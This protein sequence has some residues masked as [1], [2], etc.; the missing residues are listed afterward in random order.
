MECLTTFLVKLIP[1]L[2]VGWTPARIL[3]VSYLRSGAWISF[4]Q[5][6][7]IS[8]PTG[9]SIKAFCKKSGLACNSID[10]NNDADGPVATL[11]YI[12]VADRPKARLLLYFHGGAYCYPIDTKGQLPFALECA[13]EAGASELVCLEYTL[14]PELKYPGQLVQA[15]DAL[16]YI[17]QTHQPSQIILGGDSAG[18]H[19]VL[20]L[21]A[22]IQKPHPAAKSLIGRFR[23]GS[24]L[25][26]AYVISPWVSMKYDSESFKQNASRDYISAK[27]MAACTEMWNPSHAQVWGELLAGDVDFWRNLPVDKLLL[28]AGGWECFLDD[29]LVM[30]SRLEAKE[31]GAGA[32]VELSIGEKEVHVQCALDK[33]VG[34]PH[35]RGAQDI[36]SW[37]KRVGGVVKAEE[38]M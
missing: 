3:V 4:G 19:L 13:R 29:I 18:G 14:A 1:R 31:F 6:R 27:S 21:L 28:T 2:L 23:P 30:A 32:A 12:H 22:H 17:L 37:L 33:A 11:H 16:E 20:S 26:G 38:A 25:L 7:T 15:V 8:L 5:S 9:Q 36:L 35:G 34:A 10:I 24:Q